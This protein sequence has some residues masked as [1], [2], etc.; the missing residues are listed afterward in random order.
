MTD[1]TSPPS[2][3]SDPLPA[4][5]LADAVRA[6]D[7]VLTVVAPDGRRYELAVLWA[8]DGSVLPL[9]DDEAAE[10]VA[11]ILEEQSAQQP[12]DPIVGL[13]VSLQAAPEVGAPVELDDS[14]SGFFANPEAV[15]TWV[16]KQLN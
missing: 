2:P 13:A 5:G 3:A 16:H 10:T 8:E 6:H 11:S 4:G 7:A 1:N 15:R 14:E 9:W 12:E